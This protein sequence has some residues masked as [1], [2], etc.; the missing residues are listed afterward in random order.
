MGKNNDEQFFGRGERRG[1]NNKQSGQVYSSPGQGSSSYDGSSAYALER[2]E[3]K[4]T[5]DETCNHPDFNVRQFGEAQSSDEDFGWKD[6]NKKRKQKI[7]PWKEP[8][9][10]ETNDAWCVTRRCQSGEGRFYRKLLM[11]ESRRKE[12]RSRAP[13]EEKRK[14][15]ARRNNV[16]ER[17]S[18][19][20]L[21]RSGWRSVRTVCP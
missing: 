8:R 20:S 17:T 13:R 9:T 2:S 19:K 14:G 3:R 1:T 10:Q 18:T 7:Q 11:L 5:T 6:S 21:G 16:R 4:D 15:K 12:R